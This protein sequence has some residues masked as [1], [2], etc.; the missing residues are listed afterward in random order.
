MTAFTSKDVA[1]LAG[2][3]QSTVSYVMSGKRPISEETRR[4]VHDAIE[5]LTYQPN[6]GARALASQ[7]TNVVGLVVPFGPSADG[8]GLLPFI[9][10]IAFSARAQDY[11]VLL[12]T[13]DEGSAGLRRLAGRSLCDGILMMDIQ[14]EDERV[15]VAATLRTPVIL[16]GVPAEPQGLHCVDMDFAQAARLAIGELADTGHDRVVILQHPTEVVQRDLNYVDR[17]LGPAVAVAADRRLPC[18][19]TEPVERGRAGANRAVDQVLA[20]RIPGERLGL[21]VPNANAV[22]PVLQALNARGVAP[23]RDLSVIGVCM[24]AWAE[25]CEPP[26]TNVSGE[27]RDVSRRAMQTLFW[28]LDPTPTGPP[29]VVDLLEPRLTR[30]ESVMP[31]P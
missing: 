8:A 24:D 30:R 15:P 27:A 31:I 20:D 29:P 12:V 13:A 26:V 23:G 17:F 28:L 18:R 25:N 3:S 19:V 11:E 9:E 14:T 10:S 4:R 2:V 22:Q 1:R 21:V 5:R 16:I 7:R 6:A